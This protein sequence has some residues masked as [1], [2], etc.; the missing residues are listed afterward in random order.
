M[1]YTAENK[2]TNK[3]PKLE[4]AH[5]PKSLYAYDTLIRSSRYTCVNVNQCNH[6]GSKLSSSCKAGKALLVFVVGLIIYF[7]SLSP[8]LVYGTYKSI[9]IEI[10][11]T[12]WGVQKQIQTYMVD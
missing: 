9:N 2:Q 12:E 7:L 11:G 8:V 4:K 6:F 1:N 3:H 10:N 5:D